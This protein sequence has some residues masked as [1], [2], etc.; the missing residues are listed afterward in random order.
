MP[1]LDGVEVT[2]RIRSEVGQEVPVIIL[3]A[4]DW[5][6]IESEARAAGVTAF[7]SKPFYRSKICY[8][9]SELDEERKPLEYNPMNRKPDFK[10]RRVL[11]VE[12][13]YLNREIA[14][15][16]IE[17]MGAS[18]EEA[19]DGREAVQR[20]NDSPEGYYWLIL[21]DIQMPVMDG[22]EATKAIRLLER[23]DA[24]EVPIIAM[25]AN[26]FEEDR[27][28]ALQMGMTDHFSKPVDVKELEKLMN[29]YLDGGE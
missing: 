5:A 28:T 6:E 21:M 22:Y 9:L 19:F 18:V 17:E 12:D 15:T 27:R 1:D 16:L 11:L 13:N 8:L 14:R 24:R 3:T 4:Y 2:R 29:R 20:F 25:T 10:G 26:A 7:L 23:Q